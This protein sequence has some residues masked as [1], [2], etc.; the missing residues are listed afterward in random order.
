VE[1]LQTVMNASRTIL[2]DVLRRWR[3]GVAR[4]C[5][6][7]HDGA[8]IPGRKW[9]L[10]PVIPTS[11][12]PLILLV[13]LGWMFSGWPQVFN[14]PPGIQEARAANVLS[15][16]QTVTG[17]T[18]GGATTAVA[19]AG[20]TALNKMFHFCSFSG[21][22]NDSL[23]DQTYKSTALTG[24]GTLTI[25]AGQ[26]GGGNRSLTYRCY[27]V[28]FTA[29]SDLVVNRYNT[30]SQVT[31]RNVAIAAVSAT[32]RAFVI[33]H[34]ENEPTDTTIGAEELWRYRLTTTT[35]VEITTDAANNSAGGF[36]QFEVV[37]WNNS[38]IRVQHLDGTVG[39]AVASGTIPLTSTVVLN[40][41]WLVTTFFPVAAIVGDEQTNVMSARADLQD[42][43]TVR[44]QRILGGTNRALNWTA[45]VI[46]DVSTYG[47]WQTQLGN[48]SMT[49]AQTTNTLA[50]TAVNTANTFV[51][52]TAFPSFAF[53][54]ASPDTTTGNADNVW[55]TV[56][57]T[58]ST[59]ITAVRGVTD[60][61]TL[62]I[63][64][65]A[66]EFLPGFEQSAYRL[67]DNLDSTNVGAA[68][69]AQNTPATLGST[70]VA[71]RLRSL[72]H[73]SPQLGLS[74][75]QFKLQFVGKGTGTCAAP[76]GGTPATYTDVT[77]ATVIAY[78]NNAT[79]ADNAALTANASDPTHGADTIVNQTYEEF[80]NFTNSVAAI[81]AG[82]DGKWDF[83]LFDNGATAGTT[84]C[85]R[86]VKSDGTVL[87]TYTVFPEITTAAGVPTP[88]SLNAF[89]TSTLPNPGAI[90]GAIRTKV[91][92][93]AF[94]LDVVAIAA[95]VQQAGFTDAV[96][97]ELLGNN[98]LGVALDAQ[99]CPTSFTPLQTVAPN[100]T[101]T[102]G[103]STVN[104]AAV[105]DSWRD[106]RVRVRWPTASPTVTWCSTD[107]F[108]IRPNTLAS[109]AVTDADWQTGGLTR[110]LDDVI[111]TVPPAGK[112][113]KAGRPL[114]V[115]ATAVNAAGSPATTTN[116]VGAPTATLTTCVGAAC[117]ATPNSGTLTL[118]TTFVAGQL[119]SDVA[120]Y[121]NVG[122]FSLRLVDDVFASVD[123]ADSTALEREITSGAAINV[124]RFVPDHFAVTLSTPSF[125]SASWS[126][127]FT[128]VGQVFNYTTAPVITVT[129]RNFAGT[130]TTLYTD[131]TKW[132]RITNASL[133]GKAY[134][135]AAGALD[136]A[137]APG[138]DPVIVDAGA[139]TGTLSFSSGTG[140]FFTRTTPSAPFNS[141]IR[142]RINVLDL[143]NVTTPTSPVQ[144]GDITPGNGIAFDNSAKDMRFGRLAIRNANGSQ[145]VPLPVPLETQYWNG[146]VFVT[147]VADSCTTLAGSNIMLSNP[148]GAFTVPP[149]SCTTSASNPVN[150][151]NGRGNLVMAKPAG[152][153]V[154]SVDLDVNLGASASG[155][156][157][158]GGS[159]VAH[160]AANRPYL[161]GNWTGGAYNVNPSARAT[162]GV[163]KGAEE[164]IFI[165]ENF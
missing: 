129:A 27:I 158:V 84:Y 98:S 36:L 107:N 24:I 18:G 15:S 6:W 162:F 38:D 105:A 117:T 134:A 118:N 63:F 11:K 41:T 155:N 16:I 150:F 115:R 1:S 124:G 69:A 123:N 73:V 49:T 57:L 87:K 86:V 76:T 137:G 92:G 136:T 28:I 10:S 135:W 101:I 149:G 100:P 19:F 85:L 163:F 160:S 71:F 138:T 43:N 89:E 122:S 157:C 50:L 102:G 152:G 139:G 109:F 13:V 58:N 94:T 161:Q 121:D 81:P 14:F 132:W 21:N 62:D 59:T 9:G 141:E 64:V 79:P 20:G 80:N 165:R 44:L 3:C 151:S 106:V 110:T 29:G 70:G 30:N 140:F 104:L 53:S 2:S 116:Y 113:H 60:A 164:V 34:G 52:G 114:S 4:V 5:R 25:T 111:F 88:G 93:S 97:V 90:T 42:V 78:T 12:Y 159:S 74:G 83:A 146:T 67:F 40:K 17:A 103:R 48:I 95:G 119:T 56:T 46:E 47:L 112:V 61:R 31:P 127:G 75:Q 120:S 148:Q 65:Q 51:A 39:V 108:A 96:I 143:D 68:L 154:G 8:A 7:G 77:V 147:N 156:T 126:C 37:D 131:S 125:G 22:V 35:N 128:Y 23:H 144:F 55:S 153:A 54:G 142:L 133:T 26:T 145:L 130:D 32:N 72:I 45:Q 82:Q 91:A 33:P 99:N 66:V